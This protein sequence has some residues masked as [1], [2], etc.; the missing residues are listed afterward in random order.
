MTQINRRHTIT[1]S[2]I[3]EFAYCPRAWYLK[4]CGEEPQSPHLER[5]VAFH[6]MHESGVSQAI[7]L[8]RVGKKLGMI[9]LIILITMAIAWFVIEV[10]K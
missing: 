6:E 1:A 3:G 7:L 2:E 10:S 9:A 5:G 4:R 8:N